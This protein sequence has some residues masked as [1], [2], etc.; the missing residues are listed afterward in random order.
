MADRLRSVTHRRNSELFHFRSGPQI[1]RKAFR[2]SF[3]STAD[4]HP[5]LKYSTIVTEPMGEVRDAE[6]VIAD[7]LPQLIFGENAFARKFDGVMSIELTRQ[8]HFNGAESRQDDEGCG[9]ADQSGKVE[10]DA[11]ED[12]YRCGHPDGRRRRQ[13]ANRQ[14]FFEN[15][16]G[17]EKTDA[18]HDSL[19]HPCRIGT[20]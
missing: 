17:T 9:R 13:P 14:T 4:H 8:P 11:D 16:A 19:R 2:V 3:V 1:L 15:D 10:S 12:S 6:S 20:D 5:I 18:G 7:K